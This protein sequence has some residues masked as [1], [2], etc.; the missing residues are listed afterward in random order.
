MV[1][2]FANHG[3]INADFLVENGGEGLFLFAKIQPYLERFRKEQSPLAFKNAEWI[4]QNCHEGKRRFEMIQG[5]V[6]KMAETM[7]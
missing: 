4:S 2:G 7:K 6:K 5:R 3:I 1:Y